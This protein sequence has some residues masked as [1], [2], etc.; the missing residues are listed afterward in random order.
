MLR[1]AVVKGVR[2]CGAVV[3]GGAAVAGG[4]EEVDCFCSRARSRAR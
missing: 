2:G 4:A 1:S 3:A